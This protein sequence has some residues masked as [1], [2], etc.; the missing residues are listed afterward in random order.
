MK[1]CFSEA[2]F[3]L[4]I[5]L[6]LLLQSCFIAGE[7]CAFDGLMPKKV[8]LIEVNPKIYAY[9]KMTCQR[10]TYAAIIHY[11]NLRPSPSPLMLQKSLGLYS[12]S[13]IL[14]A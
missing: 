7:V 2:E 5:Q 4:C 1:A 11:S 9:L 14:Y 12:I 8:Q 3:L 6:Y 10:N 13:G